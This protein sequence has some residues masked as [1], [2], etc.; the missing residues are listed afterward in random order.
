MK[1]KRK[2][3]FVNGQSPGDGVALLFA[4]ASLHESYPDQFITDVKCPYAQIFEGNPIITSIDENDPDVEIIEATY[5]TI[6]FSNQKPYYFI[7]SFLKDMEKSLKIQISPANFSG[8]LHIREEEKYWY[9]AIYEILGKDVP[10]W[11][12]DA[13][14]KKDFTAKQWEFRRFQS[15]INA[16]PQMT[17]VQIGHR[18]E[19]GWHVHP[20]L[21]G[22]NLIN[23][24]GKTDIRQLIRLI[25]NSFGVITP[26]SMPMMLSYAIPPHPRFNRSSRACIV[27]S[28]G[29]EPNHWQMGPNQQFL[30]KCGILDCCDNGGCWKSR[31]EPIFLNPETEEEKKAEEIKNSSVCLRPVITKSGQ[32]IAKCMDMI[33]PDDV[34]YLIRQYMEGYKLMLERTNPEHEFLRKKKKW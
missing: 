25:Y 12:I 2:I 28:G 34:I 24:V 16:F 19:S 4:I 21:H 7:L 1:S 30:H 13:G 27:L 3:I 22:R 15:V 20:E 17:F 18:D 31:I 8:F 10:Y 11:V 29:R 33:K 9:S 23:L 5:E 6:H 14:F 32:K 26:V